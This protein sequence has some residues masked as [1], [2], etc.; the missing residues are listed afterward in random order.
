MLF[1]SAGGP[2]AHEEEDSAPEKTQEDED[3]A[4]E[5]EVQTESGEAVGVGDAAAA[6]A[7]MDVQAESEVAVGVEEDAGVK[8]VEAESEEAV[9]VEEDAAASKVCSPTLYFCFYIFIMEE[10]G[11]VG[12]GGWWGG[13][14]EGDGIQGKTGRKCSETAFAESFW[15]A[16]SKRISLTRASRVSTQ[17]CRMCIPQLQAIQRGRQTRK[18]N[19]LPKEN[20]A[21]AFFVFTLHPSSWVFETALLMQK[22]ASP[23]HPQVHL[24]RKR[25]VP[26]LKRMYKSNR[27]RRSVLGTLLLKWMYNK[28]NRKWRSVLKRMLVQRM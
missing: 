7:E 8:D 19:I 15:I 10:G 28:Q 1:P 17:P 4:P 2:S 25:R 11:W 24:R 16:F 3:S 5:K 22:R 21:G 20:D 23:F 18:A 13:G 26:L 14:R 6:A 12:V 9:G 27:K